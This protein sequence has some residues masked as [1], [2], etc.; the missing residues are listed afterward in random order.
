MHAPQVPVSSHLKTS[1]RPDIDGLRAVAV[2]SV[3]WFH[4]GAPMPQAWRLPGGFTGVDVFFVISGFLITSRLMDDIGDGQFS[5]L[6][7]YDRRI[8][9]IL[10]A[11][12]AMLTSTLVASYFLLMPGDYK[13]LAASAA[14][15][16]FGASN[17]FFLWNTGYFDQA[18]ELMPL[19]HTWSLAV[20]EQFYLAWP[21][22]LWIIA[23]RS[24]RTKI[25]VALAG[26]VILGFGA[27]LFWFDYSPKSAF[28]T[29]IPRAWELAIGAL[30]VFLPPLPRAAGEVATFAGAALIGTGFFVVTD[31][32]FPGLSALYPC[33]GA[34]LVIWPRGNGG[35]IVGWLSRLRPIGLISYSLYL[36]HWPAWVLF[37]NYI[38]G[39]QPRI[40]EAAAFA[41]ISVI[42]AIFSY[43]YI[44]TPFRR[45]PWRAS[46]VVF[47]GL[48]SGLAVFLAAVFIH[49]NHGLPSRL[50][51]EEKAISSLNVMWD[52]PCPAQADV[53]G[54]RLCAF[55]A[56]WESAKKRALLWGDSHADHFVPLLN[57]AGLETDT[58]FVVIDGCSPVYGKLTGLIRDMPP[59][60]G[61]KYFD[62]CSEKTALAFSVL[63][64]NPDILIVALATPWTAIQP[65]THD[66]GGGKVTSSLAFEGAIRKTLQRIS[67]PGRSLVLLGDV[68]YRPAGVP[69]LCTYP[70]EYIY[71]RCGPV[72]GLDRK[73]FARSIDET[74]YAMLGR[75]SATTP[76]VSVTYPGRALCRDDHCRLYV[77]GEY[78]YRDI[79]HLRR[80]LSLETDRLLAADFGITELLRTLRYP[81][82]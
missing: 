37:R 52:W 70:Q 40:R 58:A 1:Y 4:Y 20:E 27:S 81:S 23:R 32:A 6:S 22:I 13:D 71:R 30:L 44:E 48:A 56:P 36:W 68:P 38:N 75:I 24:S 15:A 63:D 59:V 3:L 69:L 47:N 17:L 54:G 41:C 16:A 78:L 43:R 26:I 34:A 51:D 46:T 74:T 49:I 5:I 29:A 66:N 80:N 28:F 53:V 64:Q 60:E 62:W 39:A 8:R 19:L 57:Q 10:P 7:F 45:R 31:T 14:A 2:L 72:A 21:V 11:L 65:L 73:T 79:D 9:R 55:G 33:L 76:N 18:A 61:K 12:I 42:L 25:A 82:N 50:S 67:A 77:N 35:W